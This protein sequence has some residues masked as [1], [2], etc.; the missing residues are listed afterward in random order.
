MKQL[1]EHYLGHDV[2]KSSSVDF[3]V[4]NLAMNL[5]G[6]QLVAHHVLDFS[7]APA[8]QRCRRFG[9]LVGSINRLSRIVE[10]MAKVTGIR[11]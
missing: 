1:S 6:V 11:W 7:L 5:C 9:K 2:G 3:R 10:L 4:H 8:F